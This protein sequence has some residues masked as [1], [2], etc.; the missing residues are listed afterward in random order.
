SP[1]WL[2]NWLVGCEQV[3][4]CNGWNHCCVQPTRPRLELHCRS[5]S[6]CNGFSRHKSTCD[7]RCRSMT[8]VAASS[9][10]DPAIMRLESGVPG[11]DTILSG[12]LLR[13]GV[14]L[15][16]GSAGAGK[17]ILSNQIMY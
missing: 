12:G 16:L 10:Q 4:E 8:E 6:E 13:G 5:A 15:I 9:S 3:G 2:R 14:Y 11:L 7:S 17:T 1:K